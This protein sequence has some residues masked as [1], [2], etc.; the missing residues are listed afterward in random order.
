MRFVA[1]GSRRKESPKSEEPAVTG[2]SSGQET[3]AL[4]VGD[5]ADEDL[6]D[7]VEPA[8]HP[9]VVQEALLVLVLSGVAEVEAAAGV[10]LAAGERR[11]RS[12]EAGDEVIGR[13]GRRA[14]P[15]RNEGAAG[16]GALEITMKLAGDTGV[17]GRAVL[18]AADNAWARISAWA[19][20][21]QGHEAPLVFAADSVG[22]V[23][24]KVHLVGALERVG[25]PRPEVAAVIGGC[26]REGELPALGGRLVFV[27][28]N[29]VGKGQRS[30]R[31]GARRENRKCQQTFHVVA[32]F[33][34][35]LR[36]PCVLT[37]PVHALPEPR[38]LAIA[39]N[40]YAAF[41]RVSAVTLASETR[42]G[43]RPGRTSRTGERPAAA[44]PSEP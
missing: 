22:A 34:M 12:E 32:P 11:A 29:G 24:P 37:C 25:R 7:A 44:C 19:L 40:P 1:E 27:R 17:E 18:A 42:A 2:S 8:V 21:G 28:G 20:A 41:T 5:V 26:H 23:L 6:V 43:C 36:S 30:K 15:G 31:H 4:R 33:R 9:V 16:D 38:V 3:R 39:S 13:T 10:S 35:E 14:G